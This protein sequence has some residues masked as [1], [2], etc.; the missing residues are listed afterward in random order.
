MVLGI[1]SASAARLLCLLIASSLLPAAAQPAAQSAADLVLTNGRIFTGDPARPWAEAVAIK[2]ER[3]AAL[4]SATEIRAQAPTSKT[5]DLG[6]RLLIPGINDAHDHAG[7][8]PFGV[9]AHTRRS[10]QDNPALPEVADAVREAAANAPK[11]AWILLTTGLPAMFDPAGTRAAVD[12]VAGDHPVLI[13]AWWGHG[14]ILNDAGLKVLGIGQDVADTPGGH[15]QRDASGKLNG[16]LEEYAGWIVLQKLHS[17]ASPAAAA[18]DFHDYAARRLAEGVTSVQVM[19][20]YLEPA[21]FVRAVAQANTPL[22]VRLAPYPM[23][24]SPDDDGM[25]GWRH[26]YNRAGPGTRV[27]GTKWVIDGTPIDGNAWYTQPYTGRFSGYG[28]LNFDKAFVERELRR[29]L[30]GGDQVLLHVSGDATMAYVLDAIEKLAPPARWRPLR[31]RIEHSQGLVGELA[32]R[33][34]ALGV[35]VAQPRPDAPLRELTNAGITVAYGS[36]EGFRPFYAMKLMTSATNPQA[37]T[38]QQAL[39]AMTHAGALAEFAEKDK[40]RIMPGMLADLVLLS[41]DVLAVPEAELPK[42]RSLL[43]L[44]GGKIAYRAPEF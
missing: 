4:G 42:T 20:G 34:A 40:G 17:G 41:Q 24:A 29:A 23:P 32:R 35:I 1:T 19:A 12:A 33:A 10:P 13:R 9:E 44:V 39:A 25:A 11:G 21:V 28:H 8:A 27:F 36:D 6:G 18:K 37:I 22:R 31:P 2:G 14:V 16:K 43:T 15:Y 26:V 5:I 30:A 7:A 3:I 38:R